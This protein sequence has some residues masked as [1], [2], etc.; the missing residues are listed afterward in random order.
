M[1]DNKPLDGK[2]VLVAITKHGAAQAA[3]LAAMLPQADVI[4]SLKFAHVFEHVSNT[5]TPY[6][7]AL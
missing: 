6:E 4:T 3:N 1:K 2:V 7:G 5:V